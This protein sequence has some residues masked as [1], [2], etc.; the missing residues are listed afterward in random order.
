MRKLN[1]IKSLLDYLLIMSYIAMPA[2]F[3]LLILQLINPSEDYSIAFNDNYYLIPEDSSLN[4]F[5]FATKMVAIAVLTYCLF[6]F[7]KLIISL[8]KR[9]FFG[10]KVY[11]NLRITGLTFILFTIFDH[12]PAFGLQI[13][14]WI[15]IIN[16]SIIPSTFVIQIIIG[17]FLISISEIIQISGEIK[18]ENDLTV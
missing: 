11:N 10:E 15:K 2:G 3:V 17:L 9:D 4:I 12:V 18:E 7:R 8:Q 16:H 5:V 6:H 1:L 13:F 14:G